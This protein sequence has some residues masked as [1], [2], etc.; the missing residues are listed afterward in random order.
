MKYAII[1]WDINDV[2]GIHTWCMNFLDATKNVLNLDIEVFLVGF[3]KS[4]RDI[5]ATEERHRRRFSYP[6]CRYL[7]MHPDSS[8]TPWSSSAD[9]IV[10]SSCIR[11]RILRMLF[12]DSF[13][14]W[15]GSI[16]GSFQ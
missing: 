9:T 7:S 10:I 15:L 6:P 5:S 16:S 2:G 12:L 4:K 8:A 13:P 3:N 14:R 1:H 11:L